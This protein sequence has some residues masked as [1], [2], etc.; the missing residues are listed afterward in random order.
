MILS[1]TGDSHHRPR[2]SPI[3]R[4][5]LSGSSVQAPSKHATLEDASSITHMRP[6]MESTNY[7]DYLGEA[8]DD[9]YGI[10]VKERSENNNTCSKYQGAR[11]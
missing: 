1:L 4:E 9:N 6:S 2:R 7:C 11:Y 8:V 10:L 5:L 3:A